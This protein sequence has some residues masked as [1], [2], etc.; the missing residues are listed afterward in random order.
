MRLRRESVNPGQ[1][2]AFALQA[3]RRVRQRGEISSPPLAKGMPSL[4]GTDVV[5]IVPAPSDT[6]ANP[7]I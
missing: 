3:G 5:Q 1:G 2:W 6:A 7:K 4:R